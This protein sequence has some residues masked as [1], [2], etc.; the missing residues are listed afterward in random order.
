M[1]AQARFKKPADLSVV[2]KRFGEVYGELDTMQRKDMKA[3]PNHIKTI[4]D[5]L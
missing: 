2:G 1:E 4:L 3:P 5:G